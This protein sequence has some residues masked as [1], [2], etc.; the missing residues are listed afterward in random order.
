MT[1]SI[2]IALAVLLAAGLAACASKAPPAAGPAPAAVAPAPAAPA[3]TPRVPPDA[4]VLGPWRIEQARSAPLADRRSARLDFRADGTIVGQASCNDFSG[5]YTLAADK[6]SIGRLATTRKACSEA[7]M[8]Q[9]DRVLTA[10]ERAAR[11]TVPPHG[12]LTLH[13]ADGAVLM[14]ASRFEPASDAAK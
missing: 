14:R 9:E 3:A 6:L 7:L 12:F 13:D 11:A 5:R 1:A 2:R 10:L 4:Q 8:E